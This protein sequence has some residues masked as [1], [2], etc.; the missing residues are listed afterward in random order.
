MYIDTTKRLNLVSL[1][2][3]DIRPIYGPN[4]LLKY[5]IFHIRVY[6][7]LTNQA[8]ICYMNSGDYYLSIGVNK[9]L[10]RHYL[11]FSI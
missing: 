7:F 11:R 9:S 3:I 1:K 6:V 5:Q 8:E 4:G 2:N 10:F